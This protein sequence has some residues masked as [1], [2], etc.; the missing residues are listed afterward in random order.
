MR[1]CQ[2]LFLAALGFVL[3]SACQGSVPKDPPRTHE[4]PASTDSLSPDRR[5]FLLG[6]FDPAKHPDFVVVEKPYT[7][8]PFM[9][10]HK[11][12]FA[13]FRKMHDA[14]SKEGVLLKI[15]SATRNFTQQKAIWEG[16]WA[17]NAGSHPDPL[18]RSRKILQYSAMPGSSRH[19]WGTDIDLNDLNNGAFLPGGAQARVYEWLQVHAHEYGFCQPYTALDARRPNGYNEERWH[20]SYM[21]VA[22]PLLEQ[23]R[24]N[25]TDADFTGFKGMETAAEVGV[26]KNYVLGIDAGC[27]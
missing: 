10:M 8:R 19:H 13:A 26:V 4:E 22:G 23:F 7:D 16:K 24:K 3:V 18:T 2:P 9:Y 1:T 21:P 6:Q 15:L 20:W 25:I 5:H 11:D 27:R 17:K 12:A 14:A